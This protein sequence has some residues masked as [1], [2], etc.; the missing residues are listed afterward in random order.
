MDCVGEGGF[1]EYKNLHFKCV[2]VCVCVCLFVCA[3][4]FERAVFVLLCVRV[5]ILRRLC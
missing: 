3:F 1:R 5:F 4:C 2:C